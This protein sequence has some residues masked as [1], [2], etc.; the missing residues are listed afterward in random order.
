MAVEE[1]LGA[2]NLL[3]DV[4]RRYAEHFADARGIH[5]FEIEKDHVS[6]DGLQLP[7]EGA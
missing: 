3:G 7:D 5:F 6:I 1:S 2:M 4:V